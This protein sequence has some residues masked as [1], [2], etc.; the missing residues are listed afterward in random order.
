MDNVI[1]AAVYFAV[2]LGGVLDWK[3]RL[4]KHSKDRHR[5]AGRTVRVGGKVC[6]M[7]K[8]VQKG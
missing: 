5:Q 6:G 2:T 3:V 7:G 1:Y 4:P 8:R